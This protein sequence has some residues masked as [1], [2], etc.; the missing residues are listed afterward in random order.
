VNLRTFLP[1]AA[2][3]TAEPPKA[4]QPARGLPPPGRNDDRPVVVAFLRHT[5]CPFAEA[6]MHALRDAAA[7]HPELEWVAISHAD[8]EPTQ[9]WCQAVGG[10]GDVHVLLDPERA[11]YAAW[12]LGRSSLRHFMGKRSLA[13]VARLSRNGIRNRHPEGTR[14]QQAGTFAV[15]DAGIVR[16]RHL[17]AHAG[18][19]PD[20]GAA[21]AAVAGVAATAAG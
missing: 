4:G 9:R 2:R 3:P 12:G 11:F 13:E 19:L 7:A 6:T 20:L 5:G 21:A 15:D 8:A 1:P 18:D 16:W 17:P 14:W 10:R